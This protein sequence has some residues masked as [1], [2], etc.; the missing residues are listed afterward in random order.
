[1][2]EK[3]A[4]V[5]NNDKYYEYHEDRGHMTNECRNLTKDLN[6][7]LK[8]STR[9]NHLYQTKEW[10]TPLFILKMMESTNRI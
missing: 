3:S 9:N 6:R 10:S 4:Y 8:E 2:S 1:M 5:R 7:L